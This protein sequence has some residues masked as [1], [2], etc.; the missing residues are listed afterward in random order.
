MVCSCASV[1]L[2]PSSSAVS[3]STCSLRDWLSTDSVEHLRSRASCLSEAVQTHKIIIHTCIEELVW[4][5]ACAC[6]C[7][8][9]I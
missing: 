4:K 7:R 1:S 6:D 8:V 3:D 5:N 9:L 2:C